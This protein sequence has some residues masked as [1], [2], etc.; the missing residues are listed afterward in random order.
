MPFPSDP[1][2]Q[3]IATVL[4][5][6]GS[7]ALK[8][9]Q[10]DYAI[11]CYLKCVKL[12]P[13]N[14][15]Y[16]KHLRATEMKKYNNDGKGASGAGLRSSGARMSLKIARTRKKWVDVVEAA[17]DIL[18]LNP[19]DVDAS[20][21][22]CAAIK[23]IG[24]E[25]EI[26]YWV[27]QSA[28]AANKDR[29]D[30][31][32]TMAYFAEQL[33]RFNEAIVALEQVKKLDPA[34]AE[35]PMKI[36]QLAASSTIKR[37][38]YEDEGSPGEE[39]A[40]EEGGES[41]KAE[42][43][44]PVIRPAA[45]PPETDEEK[46]K[47]EIKEAEEKVAA[48]PTVVLNYV[49]LGNLYRQHN[50]LDG[51]AKAYDRG[52]KSTNDTELRQRFLE[53]RIDQFKAREADGMALLEKIKDDKDRRKMIEKQIDQVAKA[54]LKAEVEVNRIRVQY[55][56]DDYAAWV[57]MGKLQ[58]DLGEYDEAIK[59]LQRGRSDMRKKWEAQMYLGLCFWQKKNFPLAE[60]NLSDALPL[61][62]PR[63]EEGKK[64]LYYYRGRVAEDG[65]DKSL[66]VECYNEVA[67]IDYGFMDVADRLDKL[68]KSE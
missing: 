21:E 11:D 19:W 46:A 14:L 35:V 17:E 31:F 61:V 57:E 54:R 63:D 13:G 62:P 34:D 6:K 64:K 41:K 66:A 52:Y 42:K 25:D 58:Y 27:A 44:S 15:E 20:L 29:A 38:G 67:A 22:I 65:G 4:F 51:A 56:P 68:N 40:G 5:S 36:R 2:K 50:D 37:G 16:R 33:G 24:D 26:G 55:K 18:Q 45:P 10:L 7:A 8:A 60:K 3:K 28:C 53:V 23:E 12:A 9:N 43:Q 32:R 39:G 30:A 59:S 47:R 48:E 1:K 49:N